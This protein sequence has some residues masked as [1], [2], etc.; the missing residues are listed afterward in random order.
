VQG[1]LQAVE[2]LHGGHVGRAV[3]SA[4]LPLGE[5][6]VPHAEREAKPVA[7]Y[8]LKTFVDDLAGE[9]IGELNLTTLVEEQLNRLFPET[10][11]WNFQLAADSQFIQVAYGPPDSE[12]PFLPKN[13]GRLK[14]VRLVLWLRSTNKE[15]QSLARLSRGPLA[16]Q[17]IRR[18]LEAILE[19]STTTF[20]RL[21]PSRANQLIQKY[22]E[23]AVAEVGTLTQEVS[24][25]AVGPWIAISM[26]APKAK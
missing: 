25:D 6:L 5:H 7:E 26:A 12:V 11:D 8:I 24:V 16:R 10:R 9:I 21:R 2:G 19:Q 15:A 20:L 3:G 17:L 4:V 14:N 13:P 23:V 22:F 18:Y 1:E